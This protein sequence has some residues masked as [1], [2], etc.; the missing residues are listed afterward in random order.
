MTPLSWG[1]TE[2]RLQKMLDMDS[3]EITVELT[4]LIGKTFT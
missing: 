3:A 1:A 2:E 4:I